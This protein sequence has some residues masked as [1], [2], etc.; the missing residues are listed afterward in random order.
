MNVKVGVGEMVLR[1]LSVFAD[2]L[3]FGPQP[4]HG[5]SQASV[6]ALPGPDALFWVPWAPGMHTEHIHE[7]TALTGIK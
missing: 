2:D 4:P 6:T 7:N 1:L 5:S 3:G